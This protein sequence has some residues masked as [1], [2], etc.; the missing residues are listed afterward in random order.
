MKMNNLKALPLAIFLA[1]PLLTNGA[2]PL[3]EGGPYS[4][5]VGKIR[6]SFI[7]TNEQS[8]VGTGTID[9][10]AV[11]TTTSGSISIPTTLG[12]HDVTGIGDYAFFC[13]SSLTY[14]YVPS[15]VTS[16]G[17]WAFGG[18]SGLTGLGIPSSVTNIENCA[19]RGCS[20]LKSVNIP[21][22]V[23]NIGN[24]A[25]G[26]CSSLT[27]ITVDADNNYYQS[28]DGVL[29]DKTETVLLQVPAGKQDDYVVPATVEAIENN[30]F[31][32]CEKITNVVMQSSVT[33]IG[34][35]AFQYCTALTHITI[36]QSVTNVGNSIFRGCDNLTS[37]D[38]RGAPPSG[39]KS[40]DIPQD[41][42][43]RYNTLYAA[44]W[45][46]VIA[47]LGLTNA[48]PYVPD[49][50]DTV[51]HGDSFVFTPTGSSASFTVEDDWV[52]SNGVAKVGDDNAVAAVRMN[53]KN[54]KFDIDGNAMFVWQDYV[55]GTDPTSLTSYM[56]AAIKMD[57]ATPVVTWNPDLK[58]K[59]TYKIWGKKSLEDGSESWMCPTNALH[60][61]FRVT[62]EM[63]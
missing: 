36:P 31:W 25:F 35:Y 48:T 7:V 49:T 24:Y 16:I 9:V 40:G 33:D 23:Q 51:Q 15:S 22:S 4:E 59:R 43:V 44:E 55:A 14:V 39:L 57:G 61:F 60:R 58:D 13:L 2:T 1:S 56:T 45:A 20:G 30:A 53:R 46:P 62:V 11:P 6:W 3:P 37:I 52:I 5:I 50:T 34:Y 17:E 27:S 28:R 18:C 29:F 8:S 42:A 54:G 32:Y 41:A 47:A 10:Q 19:F 21:S 63:K 12:G 38:F 26:L